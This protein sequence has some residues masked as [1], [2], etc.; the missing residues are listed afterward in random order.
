[1]SGRATAVAMLAPT[2]F[3][4]ASVHAAMIHAAFRVDISRFAVADLIVVP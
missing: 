4:M 1:M 3:I 2:L